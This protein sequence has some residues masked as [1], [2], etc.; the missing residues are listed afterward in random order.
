MEEL[1]KNEKAAK[2]SEEKEK[3]RRDELTLKINELIGSEVKNKWM[4]N[5]RR[6]CADIWTRPHSVGAVDRLLL[7]RIR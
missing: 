4:D 6:R 5:I 2:D 3:S 7:T 1:K